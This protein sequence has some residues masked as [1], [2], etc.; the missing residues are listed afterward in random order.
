MESNEAAFAWAVLFAL[1]LIIFLFGGEPD[2]MDILAARL[3]IE[4]LGEG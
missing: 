3:R 2:V 1:S 4:L